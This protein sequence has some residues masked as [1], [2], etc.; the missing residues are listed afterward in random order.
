MSEGFYLWFTQLLNF[1]GAFILE[2]NISAHIILDLMFYDYNV[3]TKVNIV[4]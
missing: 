1:L 4:S 2:R 3:K